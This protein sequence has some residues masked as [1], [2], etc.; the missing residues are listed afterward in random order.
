I[1]SSTSTPDNIAVEI[2][3]FLELKAGTNQFGV[4]S[5]DGIKVSVGSDARDAFATVLG[6]FDTGRGV[7]ER[8]VSFVVP[9][10]GIY[11]MRLVWWEGTGGANVEWYSIV[12]GTNRILIND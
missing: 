2:L 4:S 5:D 9:V 6:L 11:P 1:P 10:D 8:W 7:A 3:T 12:S